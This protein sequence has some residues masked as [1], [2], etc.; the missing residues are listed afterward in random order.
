MPHYIV[1]DIQGCLSGLHAILEAVRFSPGGDRLLLCGDLVGRGPQSAQTL[2]FIRSLGPA[3]ITVLGNHDL[4][5]LACAERGERPNPRDK[6][7][8]LLDAADAAEQLAW[9]RQQRLA[10]REP[11]SGVLLIH[12]GLAPQWDA[13]DTLK[14]AAEVESTLRDPQGGRQLLLE[15]HGNEPGRWAD[16]LSGLPRLR[17]IINILTRARLCSADGDFDF[18]FKRAPDQAPAGL[19]PWFAAPG[20]RSRDTT[21]VFGHWSTLGRT[22]WPEH[23]VYGLDTGYLWGG[24]LTALRLEDL[25][26]YSVLATSAALE[27]L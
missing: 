13:E 15:M 16:S 23:K 3:A 8:E 12:A 21:V 11:Q 2:R 26:L 24:R 22:H 18:S 20:R 1:G 5:L 27:P 9:L 19:L 7:D 4:H 6:L 10:Y 17:C 14:L 25:R